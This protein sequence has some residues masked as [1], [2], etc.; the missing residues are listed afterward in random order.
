MVYRRHA[1][2]L[3]VHSAVQVSLP[4]RTTLQ[5]C[6]HWSRGTDTQRTLHGE[7]VRAS[8]R[9]QGDLMVVEV[10]GRRSVSQGSRDPRAA[11]SAV[12]SCLPAFPRVSRWSCRYRT[13]GRLPAATRRFSPLENANDVKDL[14]LRKR[15]NGDSPRWAES[16]HC[17]AFDSHTVCKDSS[18][19]REM[20]RYSKSPREAHVLKS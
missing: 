3:K 11:D 8:A 16:D 18:C 19:S 20:T 13:H 14:F 5:G 4:A 17:N 12:V 9:V 2:R 10:G 1:S 7:L 6:Q 15:I